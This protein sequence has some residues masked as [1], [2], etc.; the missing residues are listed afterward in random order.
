MDSEFLEN[1]GTNV[2]QLLGLAAFASATIA[3]ILAK[4]NNSN[5]A[6]VWIALATTNAAFF[7]EILF[8]IRHHLREMAV[9]L[10]LSVG[11]Y[12]SRTDLQYGL[13]IASAAIPIFIV[14]LLLVFRRLRKLRLIIATFASFSVLTLFAIEAISLHRIDEIFY[15]EIGSV[16]LIGWLWC[17]ACLATVLSALL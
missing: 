12:A 4:K 7:V 14:L 17:V 11:L 6:R 13:I 15:R 16:L 5:E 2:T 10:L 8:G 9:S 1:L 3:C